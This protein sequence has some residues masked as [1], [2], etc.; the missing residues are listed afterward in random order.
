[1]SHKNLANG[2]Y[3][4]VGSLLFKYNHRDNINNTQEF[5]A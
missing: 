1:M 2:E 3:P 4:N 5:K